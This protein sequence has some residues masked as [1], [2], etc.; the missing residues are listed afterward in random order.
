MHLSNLLKITNHQYYIYYQVLVL[1]DRRAHL[2]YLYS[3]AEKFTTVGY[4]VGGMSQ[5]EL[6]K[7]ESKNIIFGT[8]P[9]SSEGLDIPSLNAIIFTTP[10]SSIEQSIGR[11]TRQSH[12]KMPIA[13]DIVDQ[14]SM[15]P[16][17]YIRRE[18]VYKKLG[19]SVYTNDIKITSNSDEDS[20]D[21]FLDHKFR[22]KDF[23]RKKNKY[24]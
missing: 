24:L 19:Y 11:I 20:F 2:K 6:E 5:K 14:M 7:S 21:Y 13:Y 4:Y 23:K 18:R 10:K 9:M 1:S 15:F 12:K 3:L 17:Q 8:Y 16:N 22:L